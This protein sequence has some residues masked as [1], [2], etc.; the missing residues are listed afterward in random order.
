M[1]QPAKISPLKSY[2]REG[3]L[4]ETPFDETFI[5]QLK[6]MIPRKEREWNGHRRG[7]WVDLKH[8]ET[9]IHLVGDAFGAIVIVDEDGREITHEGGERLEQET[10]F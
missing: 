7:W 10:L 8:R 2:G 6:A 5:E 4:V 3:V 1:N 9:I